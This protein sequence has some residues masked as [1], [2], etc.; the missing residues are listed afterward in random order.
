MEAELITLITDKG[1]D[2]KSKK[3]NNP[4]TVL[5]RPQ[6]FQEVEAPIF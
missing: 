6:G 5:D 2:I 1:K 3:Q 4:I